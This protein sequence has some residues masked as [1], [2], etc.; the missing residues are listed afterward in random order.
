MLDSGKS[1]ENRSVKQNR[2]KLNSFSVIW[3][4]VLTPVL[5]IW[6]LITRFVF[7]VA[8]LELLPGMPGSA[9][10]KAIPAGDVVYHWLYHW[11]AHCSGLQETQL[12]LTHRVT[13][14]WKC[15]GVA[16]LLK[17]PL[18]HVCHHTEFGCSMSYHVCISSGEPTKLGST[19]AMPPWD[20]G[21]GW[22]PKN[23]PLPMNYRAQFGRS[24]LKSV[25]IDSE[26][27][28]KLV[29]TGTLPL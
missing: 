20:G 29:S 2:Q 12:L 11:L 28:Q 15:N 18:S 16:N 14:L 27:P 24:S 17:I 8:G 19:A 26:K 10:G 3:Q 21:R 4:T 22:L 1:P 23:K 25:V 9:V 7:V 6:L 5:C 13:H